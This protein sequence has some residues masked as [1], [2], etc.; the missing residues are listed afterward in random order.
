L[1]Y[2]K[3]GTI[4]Q[5]QPAIFNGVD[6]FSVA[7]LDSEGPVTGLT[8]TFNLA[9]G[10][11]QTVFA[12]PSYFSFSS[13]DIEV[14]R[15]SELGIISIVGIGSAKITATLGGV[16]A[17]GSL[18]IKCSGA[19]PIAPKPMIPAADV[20]S[21]YSDA[22]DSVTESN[23][24]PNFDGSTTQTTEAGSDGKSVLLYTNNNFTGIIFDNTVDASTLTHLHI[25]IY[26]QQ[27]G[28]EV[29]IQIRDIGANGEIESDG[30]G[31]PIG[32]DKD[33][34]FKATGLALGEWTSFGIPLGG[35][36]TSQKN[37]LGALIL[38]DGPD[39]ILDNIY[40]YKE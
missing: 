6:E 29:G 1:K 23:F 12:A 18:T 7:F 35:D 33:F 22:Y 40:F 38:V 28:T 15:V 14:A 16:K 8:Q 5:P 27:A 11:N 24:T 25:D 13:S 36:L 9:S 3:L 17:A 4:A 34:R 31:N 2:E 21:I 39:F 19:L 37:N 10:I 30:N 26:T 20:K 32:D